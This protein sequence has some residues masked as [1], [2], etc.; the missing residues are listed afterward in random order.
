MKMRDAKTPESWLKTAKTVS[1]AL[2]YMR[3]FAG[4]T[5]VIKYGGHAMGDESLAEQFARDVIVLRQMG[6]FHEPQTATG[7]L[8]IFVTH[9][10]TI[11]RAFAR[12]LFKS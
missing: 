8:A 3:E 7:M 12:N 11:L 10:I 5:F 2:P 4:E 1:E 6:I 9:P